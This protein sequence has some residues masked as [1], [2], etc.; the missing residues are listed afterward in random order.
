[1]DLFGR[2][3]T[4]AHKSGQS[5][6]IRFLPSGLLS[7][8]VVARRNNFSISINFKGPSSL[9]QLRSKL[10]DPFYEYWWIN[11]DASILIRELLGVLLS[12]PE[13]KPK[14]DSNVLKHRIYAVHIKYFLRLCSTGFGVRSVCVKQAKHLPDNC[15]IWIQSNSQFIPPTLNS[16]I[17]KDLFMSRSKGK[18]DN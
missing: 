11:V 1:M 18:N 6:E 9:H 7:R 16:S 13:I 10:I 15:P 2:P 12:I 17:Y 3:V 4:R 8:L 5:A 14:S